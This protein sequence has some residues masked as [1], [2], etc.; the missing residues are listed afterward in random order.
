ML[1]ALLKEIVLV[2][3]CTNISCE[4]VLS[5]STFCCILHFVNFGP[6]IFALNENEYVFT[7]FKLSACLSH[8]LWHNDECDSPT[9]DVGGLARL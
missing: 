1:V 3:L 9:S 2:V 8:T 4:D 5:S 7:H 6:S